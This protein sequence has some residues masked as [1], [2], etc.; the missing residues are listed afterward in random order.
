MTYV[1]IITLLENYG[2]DIMLLI[3]VLCEY[4]NVLFDI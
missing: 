3:S 1:V 4:L 2:I